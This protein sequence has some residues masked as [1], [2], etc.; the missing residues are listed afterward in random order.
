MS[1]SLFSVSFWHFGISNLTNSKAFSAPFERL[2]FFF[3][4]LPAVG[5]G[6]GKNVLVG[7]ARQKTLSFFSFKLPK[8]S[9]LNAKIVVIT[10]LSKKNQSYPKLS[11]TLQNR[12]KLSATIKSYLEL[13]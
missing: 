8:L 11:R 5:L 2:D 1:K 4:G 3:L 6:E 9:H 7:R 12:F 10:K 13:S